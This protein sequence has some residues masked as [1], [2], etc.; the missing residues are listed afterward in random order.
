MCLSLSTEDFLKNQDWKF[1][2]GL[3]RVESGRPFSPIGDSLTG[4]DMF[5]MIF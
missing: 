2:V 1:T 4:S 5:S 3:E